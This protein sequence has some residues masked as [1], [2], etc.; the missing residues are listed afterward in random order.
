MSD[1]FR[2]IKLIHSPASRLTGSRRPGPSLFLQNHEQPTGLGGLG[3]M[4]IY[5][6][7]KYSQDGGEHQEH[8][9]LGRINIF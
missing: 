2:L 3:S 1:K 9:L 5:K 8:S 4:R 7:G 6:M